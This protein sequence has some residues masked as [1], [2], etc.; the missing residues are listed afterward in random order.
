[1]TVPPNAFSF[2]VVMGNAYWSDRRKERVSHT[3]GGVV[4]CA[5]GFLLL[6][7]IKDNLPG[8][9]IGCFLI[10][11]TN[12]AILPLLALRAATVAGSTEAAAAT[13]FPISF[14]NLGGL[15]APFLFPTTQGP[16]YV[17]G[18]WTVFAMQIAAGLLI[19]LL[20]FRVGSSAIARPPAVDEETTTWPD[21]K[22]TAAA[23]DTVSAPAVAPQQHEE[24]K[25]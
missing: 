12:A 1:M 20:W 3:L 6:A 21:E 16:Q 19:I 9:L 24:T 22:A 2:V 8:R 13:G 17:M 15:T 25:A 23:P 14:T 11:C 10:T 4:L 5:I 7:V 18:N